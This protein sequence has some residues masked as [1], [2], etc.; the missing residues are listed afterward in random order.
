VQGPDEITDRALPRSDG[1]GVCEDFVILT[2]HW[3]SKLQVSLL[4][5]IINYHLC[6]HFSL[7]ML[8]NDETVQRICA[9]W[10]SYDFLVFDWTYIF[11]P[12]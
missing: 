1:T 4:E 6:L 5:I 3:L 10:F 11:L 2:Q 7:F 8:F 12:A 9:N